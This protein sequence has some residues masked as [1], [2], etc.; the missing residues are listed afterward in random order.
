MP[1]LSPA[2]WLNLA[3]RPRVRSVDWI[4]AH[5]K[6]PSG[7]AFDFQRVPWAR[8]VCDAWDDPR[9]R[10]VVMMWA[11][12]MVKS[13]CAS[14]C[15]LTAAA[16]DPQPMLFGSST[17]ELVKGTIRTRLYPM[18]DQ[19][20]PLR[21]QLRPPGRRSRL[22]IDLRDCR[23]KGAWSGSATSMAD[24]SSCF[25]WINEC[26]KLSTEASGEGDPLD[27]M[28]KR[29]GEY[30]EVRKVLIEGTPQEAGNSRVHKRLLAGTDCRFEVPC[31]LPRQ[32]GCGVY[33]QLGLSPDDPTLTRPMPE[34]GGLVWD[35]LADGRSDPDLARRTARYVCP[36][37][38]AV[39]GD[40]HRAEIIRR[41]VWVPRGQTLDQRGRLQGQP[42][43]PHTE[44]WSSQI[45]NL[46]TLDRTWG[47]IAGEFVAA[48]RSPGNM[49]VFRQGT[50]GWPWELRA[51]KTTTEQLGER[52]RV[53]LPA[54]TVP[55]WARYLV[56]ACDVQERSFPWLLLAIGPDEQRHV[57]GHGT[58]EKWEQLDEL[59]AR[60]WP[61]AD[62]G[63][64]LAAAIGL[65]DSGHHTIS[66]YRFARKHTRPDRPVIAC[67]G[68]SGDLGGAR[69]QDAVLSEGKQRRRAG[70]LF[71]GQR[72]FWVPTDCWEEEIAR[73]LDELRPGEPGA[74]TLCHEA[75]ADR[76]L[77]VQLLN[78]ALRETIDDRGNPRL[79]WRK[80]DGDSS[81]NDF[82]DA[83]R[84][85]LAGA[86]FVLDARKGRLPER[87][88]GAETA[89]P[90]DQAPRF[91]TPDGRP[92]LLTERE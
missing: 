70:R 47:A 41:G 68:S 50:Q 49:K 2:V 45:S 83:L 14:A 33:Q 27:Q 91:T 17:Q 85:A 18:L 20:A 16:N 77:L 22:S 21:D 11:A 31:Y 10:E 63:P 62:G 30:H 64:P 55:A 53:D 24:F 1:Q 88:T 60:R 34:G 5:V 26:D 81:A 76:D 12:R 48:L 67:K 51:S 43:Q 32:R 72:I 3:P 89:R 8:G 15:L 6:H 29:F 56:F 61:H 92:Y 39:W 52:L 13:I 86:A 73:L 4:A 84:Y 59:L 74:L 69:Y 46:Y 78:G 66:C 23:I 40:E 19:C 37:C 57:A 71:A 44:I 42:A 54:G 9:Y 28:L 35:K 65:L 38:G 58:A 90:R 79:M 75:A 36:Y 82:R 7:E 80:K 25:G 87:L